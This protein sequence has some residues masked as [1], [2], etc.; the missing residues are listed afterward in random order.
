MKIVNLM[1]NT[2]GVEGC[3]AAHGLS[4]YIETQTHKLLMD[5]GPSAETLR[6]A[7]RL[8][9]D[10]TAVDTVILSHGHYDHAGGIMAFAS[11]NP[12]AKI[13]MQR[14][15]DGEFYSADGDGTYRYI[16]IDKAITDLPHLVLVDGDHLIDGELLLLTV[17]NARHP[18]PSMNGRLKCRQGETYLP[19][20][21]RHEQSL[22]ITEGTQTVLL[23]GCAHNGIINILDAFRAKLGRDPDLVIGGFHLMKKTDYTNDELFEI[24]DL[25]KELKKYKTQFYTCHCTGI[26]AYRAMKSLMGAQLEYVHTGEEIP[27]SNISPRTEIA[28]RRKTVYMKSHKFFAWATVVC[29]VMTMI[30]G[31]KRK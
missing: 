26:P 20:T 12:S 30:T 29:F 6:N 2:A 10:L 25:A 5:L 31:Y 27:V 13:Y 9:I 3:A 11:L 16:G 8:G 21:F 22:V 24:I 28:K 17:Q 14:T 7:E 4:F 19:D 18:L 23:T 1:E 15:A